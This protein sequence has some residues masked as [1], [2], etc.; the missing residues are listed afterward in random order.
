MKILLLED[1]II[2]HES[3]QEHLEFEGWEVFSAFSSDDVY[4]LTYERVTYEEDSFHLYLFDVNVLGDNGFE[5]L[6]ALRES[7]DNTPTIFITALSDMDSLRM[8]FDVGADDYIKKPFNIEELMV[9]IQSRYKR[10]EFILYNDL[11]YEVQSRKLYKGDTPIVLS[12]ILSNLFHLLITHKNHVVS[13]DR[14]LDTLIKPNPNALRVNMSK[15]KSRLN[16]DIKNIK[17]IGYILQE[18]Q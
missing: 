14:L 10:E 16:L 7:G 13:L 1:D 6:K 17:G 8:G 12:S 2:L 5:V 18:N 4:R 3:L 15:L 11:K 9:R